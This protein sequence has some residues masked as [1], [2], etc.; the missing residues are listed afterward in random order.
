LENKAIN[1]QEIRLNNFRPVRD[2]KRFAAL[3]DDYRAQLI[4]DYHAKRAALDDDSRAKIAQLNDDYRA[5]IAALDDDYHAK[6]AP[7]QKNLFELYSVDVPQGTWNGK[8]IFD[9]LS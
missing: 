3:I 1:E 5:K 8:S 7:L 6:I 2:E 9:D 4:D